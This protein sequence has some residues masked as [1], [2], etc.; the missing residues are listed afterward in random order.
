MAD[1]DTASDPQLVTPYVK[2]IYKY[3][4][5]LEVLN[6]QSVLVWVGWLNQVGLTKS[7]LFFLG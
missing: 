1:I 3:L 7:I 2:H 6:L 4:Q 5:E